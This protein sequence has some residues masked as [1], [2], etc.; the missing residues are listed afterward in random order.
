MA[1]ALHGISSFHSNLVTDIRLAREAGFDELEIFYPKL[2]RFLQCG[3]SIEVLRHRIAD[4]G[5]KVGY[6]SAL[7]HIE[8]HEAKAFEQLLAE[9][10]KITDEASQLGAGTV[11]VLPRTGIDHLP[12]E[13]IMDIMTRNIEAIAAIGREYGIRYMI[14]LPAF[15]AF[16]S[17]AQAREIFA[18]VG[19][20]NIG[21]VVDFWHFY[22]SGATPEDVVT[23]DPRRIFGV[24]FCDGRRPHAGE[25][26][27]EEVLRAC[28]PGE[29]E[30]DLAAWSEAVHRSGYAGS[31]SIELISPALWEADPQELLPD[32]Q[33]L[34]RGYAHGPVGKGRAAPK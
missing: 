20:E 2:V 14:E 21:V 26:W 11:M 18:R 29:G 16:R 30:I 17:L 10:R 15:T 28:R 9:A 34:L 33:R 27:D 32:L 22:A 6:V 25:A 7:D 31:W 3:G 13:Q 8:R 1:T 5:L 4:A 12:Q 24:H 19:A 23:F